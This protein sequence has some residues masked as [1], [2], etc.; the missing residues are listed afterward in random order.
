MCEVMVG[1]IWGWKMRRRK[2]TVGLMRGGAVLVLAMFLMVLLLVTGGGLLALGQTARISSIRMAGEA[3]ARAA[4]DA[5]LT[6]AI[7]EMNRRLKGGEWDGRFLVVDGEGEVLGAY[8]CR[9]PNCDATYSYEIVADS[10]SGAGV[11]TIAC[12]GRSGVAEKTVYATVKRRGP[13]EFGVF[14]CSGMVLKPNT[15]VDGYDSDAGPYGSAPR[16]E[17]QI[18]TNSTEAGSIIMGKEAVVYGD[19]VVGACGDPGVVISA[20]QAT[21]T[22]DQYALSEEVELPSVTVPPAVWS[23]PAGPKIDKKKPVTLTSSARYPSINLGRG[24]SLLVDGDVTLYV[25]GDVSL[26]NSAEI[27]VNDANPEA[28][29]RLY[30]GG[31]LYCKNGG[32]LNNL[33]KDPKR[34]KIYALDSCT[35]MSFA[36]A[37]VFY[38]AIYAPNTPIYIKS[39]LE[40]YGSVVARSFTQGATSNFHYDASLAKDTNPDVGALRFS[41]VR[42]WE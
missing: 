29:L 17:V 38:G 32:T 1:S 24:Q 30:L 18:G 4:A 42:W 9:L 25:T 13:F 6:K 15:V 12:T 20:S 2:K 8:D 16:V 19:V 21:I 3:G 26:S 22:G 37:G 10:T 5:G 40:I 39:A 28:S 31:N 35:N 41:V 23:L 33:T 34:L 14:T 7:W 27:R 11:F 36:T